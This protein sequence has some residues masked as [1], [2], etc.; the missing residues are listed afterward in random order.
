VL[1]E[2]WVLD[3]LENGFDANTLAAARALLHA[4]ERRFA[5]TGRLTAVSED[6][7]DRAPWF[8]YSAVADE[9]S[10]FTARAPDATPAPLTFST[11]AA[12]GWGVLFAGSYPDRLLDAAG[13][14]VVEGE[15]LYSGRYDATGEPNRVLALDTSAVV[16]EALAYRVR[17]PARGGPILVSGTGETRR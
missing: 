3:A 9:D 7:L 8:S 4:Q 15:G 10:E 5:A 17:G 14:L 1:S 11:K 6:H 2:P 12:V 13:E 16:L